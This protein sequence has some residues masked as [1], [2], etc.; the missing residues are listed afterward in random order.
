MDDSCRSHPQVPSCTWSLLEQVASLLGLSS[1]ASRGCKA[2][3]AN[4]S[5]QPWWPET[6]STLL[7]PRLCHWLCSFRVS[8]LPFSLQAQRKEKRQLAAADE[9]TVP[10]RMD[11]SATGQLEVC[12]H[13]V[14]TLVTIDQ[15]SLLVSQ[16]A[17]AMFLRPPYSSDF[18]PAAVRQ[19]AVDPVCLVLLGQLSGF[20]VK[21]F[22]VSK[23][24]FSLAAL[25]WSKMSMV[26]CLIQGLFG[27]TAGAGSSFS[28][29]LKAAT[30][31]DHILSREA[32]SGSTHF[33]Y[34]HVVEGLTNRFA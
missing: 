26:S 7:P 32:G 4:A 10:G 2:R 6:A 34:K 30:V 20:S 16:P 8:P 12:G 24:L 19:L 27:T 13:G 11:A 21:P 25:L 31:E 18:L 23:S 22:S 1:P 15:H 29:S 5:L 9:G 3:Q 28:A 14:C 17:L 33:S